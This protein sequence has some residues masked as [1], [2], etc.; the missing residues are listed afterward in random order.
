M[1]LYGICRIDIWKF[2]GWAVFIFFGLRGL[3]WGWKG[4]Q[5]FKLQSQRASKDISRIQICQ[6]TGLVLGGSFLLTCFFFNS[7]G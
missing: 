1:Y 5:E 2:R 4:N 7:G 6:I 3:G